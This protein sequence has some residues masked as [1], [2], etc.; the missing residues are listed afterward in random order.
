MNKVIFPDF[1]VLNKKERRTYVW[2]HLGLIDTADYAVR[3]LN[4]VA[5][6][7]EA[8]YMVGQ[9]LI[10]TMESENIPLNIKMVEKKINDYLL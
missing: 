1:L 7:E 2:E 3:N 9:E 4:K 10:I 6:Y 5:H 8:G